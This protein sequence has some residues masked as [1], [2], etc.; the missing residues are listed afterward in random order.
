MDSRQ[1]DDTRKDSASA[2]IPHTA[3][4]ASPGSRKSAGV[5]ALLAAKKAAGVA[6]VGIFHDQDV[7]EVFAD[8]IIDV[9]AFAAGKIAA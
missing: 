9:T 2:A 5:V 7:R 4:T 3:P 1:A 8:R 6:L